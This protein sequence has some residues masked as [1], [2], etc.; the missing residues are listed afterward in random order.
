MRPCVVCIPARNE[1]LRLPRLLASL[2]AQ[3]GVG[4][5]TALK[6][7]VLANNCTDGTEEAVR[8]AEASGSLNGLDLR[9]ISA[10]LAPSE[11]HVG[12][13]RRMALE[14]GAEWLEAEAPGTAS[15]SPR[16]RTPAC[17]RIGSRPT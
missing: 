3:E 14:A 16:T 13:A 2:A 4:P 15:C 10:T 17:R 8:D 12:T 11:A 9:L 1:A 6:V 7:V 5:G